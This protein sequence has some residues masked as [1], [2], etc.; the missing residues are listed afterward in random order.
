MTAAP[1]RSMK[2]AVCFTLFEMDLIEQ[3]GHG[4]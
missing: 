4:A 2:C 1:C 3:A